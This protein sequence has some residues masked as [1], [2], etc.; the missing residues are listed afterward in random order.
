MKIKKKLGNILLD[1]GIVNELDMQRCLEIQKTSDHKLGEILLH[2]G[3]VTKEQMAAVLEYQYNIP[4]VELS[5]YPIDERAPKMISESLARQH[6]VIPVGK[7]NDKLVIVMED[8]FDIMARDDIKLITGMELEIIMT[9]KADILKLIDQYYDASE[10]VESAFV[11]MQ[12]QTEVVIEKEEENEEVASSPIVRV[13][14]SIIR[15]AIKTRASDIHIEPF[16]DLVRVRYRIDGA[17]KVEMN[18]PKSSLNGMV[19]RIKILGGMDIS[20]KRIPQD[21][22]IETEVDGKKVDLRVSI[23]PTVHGEK[24]VI[25]IL[26]RTSILM[27]KEKIGFTKHNIE[28]FEKIIKAPE[29]I[30]LLTGPTGSGKTTT[31]YAVLGELNKINTNII[32]AEDPVEYRLEGVN[33]VQ[34]N[35]KSGLDFPATLRSILRQDPDVIMVGEIRDSETV[36]MAVRASITGHIVLSTLHTNDTV[37]TISRLEDMGIEPFMVST[38]VVGIIAQRLVKRICEKCK[39]IVVITDEEETILKVPGGTK[40]CKGKGCNSCGNSG[41]F[42]RIAIHEVLVLNKELKSMISKS[43]PIEDIKDAAIKFGME[44]L[45][46][47]CRKLVLEGVTTVEEML[48]VTYSIDE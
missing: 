9:F 43:E 7:K 1:L 20:E 17:L 8:P 34:I 47:S 37:S 12:E 45:S 18:T 48:R 13:V 39:Y 23:L 30:I 21:G 5:N 46:E 19:T 6:T 4:F 41:Y 40:I 2:E 16:E 35:V 38:A 28:L 27:T 15:R 26:H 33:Q 36:E 24:T 3:Y 32:T 22:R 14:N 29:G 31:L 25:R 11:E 44:T 10:A 42:G